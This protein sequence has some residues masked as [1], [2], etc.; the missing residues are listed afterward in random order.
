MEFLWF[1]IIG[2]VAGFLAGKIMKGGG[3]GLLGNL[4]VG[5]IGAVLGGW[6]FGVLGI[7][8]SEGLIGS[9]ITAVVGAVVLLFIVGFFKKNKAA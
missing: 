2:A 9:L 7:S 5:I 3:F 6:L 4:I 8:V 1:L